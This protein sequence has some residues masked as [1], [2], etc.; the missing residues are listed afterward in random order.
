M[1]DTL[2]KITID[3]LVIGAFVAKMDISWLDSPFLGNTRLIKKQSEIDKLRAAGAREVV[4][5]IS[6][7]IDI[8]V[9]EAVVV[10]VPKVEREVE[11]EPKPRETRKPS[12]QQEMGAAVHIRNQVKKAIDQLHA[13]IRVDAKIDSSSFLPLVDTTIQSLARN[14]QALLSLVHISRK[15]QKLADHSFG[16]FCLSLNLALSADIPSEQREQLGLAALFHESGWA[17]LPLNLMGKR[18]RYTK[19]EASLVERHTLISE[20]TLKKYNLPELTL[21]IIAEHHERLDGSGYP[22]KLKSADIHPLTQLFSVVDVYEERVHQ[23]LD[24]PGML[25]TNALKSLYREAEAGMYSPTIVASFINMLGIYPP[26]TA[27]VLNTGE[28]AVVREVR[29]ESPLLPIIKIYYDKAGRAYDEP[30]VID[31]MDTE[32]NSD[33]RVISSVLDLQLENSDPTKCLLVTE[34]CLM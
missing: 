33:E 3:Q 16:T 6:K 2:K 23:L 15:S 30:I 14:D 29:A 34:Q 26:T 32:V 5:D 27:V 13:A 25:A 28:K 17:G 10:E 9:A 22:H 18:T 8:N 1:A 7:G 12:V 11:Q 20:K 4:I 24:S 21:R 31:L 19:G